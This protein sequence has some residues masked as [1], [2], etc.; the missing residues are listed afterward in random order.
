MIETWGEDM[1]AYE[2]GLIKPQLWM[3]DE[4]CTGNFKYEELS[5]YFLIYQEVTRK[6]YW[7]F[8]ETKYVPM[9]E[10]ITYSSNKAQTVLGLVEE[11]YK[12]IK[13]DKLL[14]QVLS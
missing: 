2:H 1:S 14:S 5:G 11:L 10:L 6:K 12:P 7:F 8:S 3:F 4:D 13:R 9:T